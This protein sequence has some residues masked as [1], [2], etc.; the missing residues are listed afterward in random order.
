MLSGKGG[1]GF[2]LRSGSR[3]VLSVY[4][5]RP[6]EGYPFGSVSCLRRAATEDAI[7]DALTCWSSERV[8][9][10]GRAEYELLPASEGCTSR[11]VGV[12]ASE[13]Y[14]CRPYA[15]VHWSDCAMYGDRSAGEYGM[16]EFGFGDRLRRPFGSSD[17][18][19]VVRLEP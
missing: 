5:Y 3:P 1:T 12:N 17:M 9:N 11:I 8:R 14:R 18:L 4:L 15:G 10:G 16:G 19:M 2:S 6:C 7:V 13:L